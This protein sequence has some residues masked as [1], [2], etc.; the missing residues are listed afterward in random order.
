MT[1]VTTK[2]LKIVIFNHFMLVDANCDDSVRCRPN[3]V[4]DLKV[5]VALK[6]IN[7]R[8]LLRAVGHPL[9]ISNPESTPDGGDS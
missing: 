4:V 5:S 1:A 2:R 3:L 7:F 6:K 9:L 8:A